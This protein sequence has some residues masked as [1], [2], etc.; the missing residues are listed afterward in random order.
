MWWRL[1]FRWS[2]TKIVKKST[3]IFLVVDYCSLFSCGIIHEVCIWMSRT[4]ES[5][6]RIWAERW[7][8]V[9]S[10]SIEIYQV[11]ILSKLRSINR[12]LWPCILLITLIMDSLWLNHL[13]Y[14][15]RSFIEAF[16]TSDI[17]ISNARRYWSIFESLFST[18]F[19]KLWSF[20]LYFWCFLHVLFR[21]IW[22]K[23][24]QSIFPV[25]SFWS[26][27]SCFWTL[28]S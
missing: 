26:S 20:I 21:N 18:N 9:L 23:F 8:W 12:G 25:K 14:R 15:F 27:N 17:V 24:V 2:G 13:K 19:T 1:V 7:S 3:F 16:K 22:S 10:F 6:I 28:W 5:L 11:C 4:S